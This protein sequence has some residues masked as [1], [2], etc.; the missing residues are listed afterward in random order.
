MAN[1]KI[2]SMASNDVVIPTYKKSEGTGTNEIE[3][4][5]II[6]GGA[7]VRDNITLQNRKFVVTEVNAEELKTLQAHPAF[8]RKVAAGF[9]SVGKEPETL[10]ADKS[11]QI[12][13]KQMKAKAP[14][15]TV[16]TGK[17][18]E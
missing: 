8:K 11:A 2:Y 15:A 6:K 3:S 14:K 13:E 9:I 10:K 5:I 18:D 17:A 1:T 16:K 7:N 12:T 4:A